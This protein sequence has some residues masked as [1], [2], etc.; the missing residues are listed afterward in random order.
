[1]DKKNHGGKGMKSELV[2]VSVNVNKRVW[3]EAK[4]ILGDIGLSRSSFINVTLTQ[5]VNE[6]KGQANRGDRMTDV[7]GSLFELSKVGRK[8]RK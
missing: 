3:K 5:L 7:V 4:A 8:K 1:M 2:K 6:S